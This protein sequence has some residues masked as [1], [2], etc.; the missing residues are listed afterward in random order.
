MERSNVIEGR[1]VASRFGTDFD[2]NSYSLSQA[3][4]YLASF[5]FDLRT[6]HFLTTGSEFYTYHSLAQELYEK[7]EEYYDD[8]VETY[9]GY[10]EAFIPMYVL[11]G[12]WEF[13]DSGENMD[14][15][16]LIP[17]M[18][19]ASRLEKMFDVLQNVSGDYDS[20]VRSKL[21]AMMEYYD[22]ELYK[23]KQVLKPV[24]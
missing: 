19:I 17:Q 3:S 16:N 10:G 8:L 7:T 6:I 23:I 24:I 11:P 2:Y 13:V 22:K 15:S 1:L 21:D 14:T 12:D 20:G 4:Q 9:V 18:L 5:F